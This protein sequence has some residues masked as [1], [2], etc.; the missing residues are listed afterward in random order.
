MRE[1]KTHVGVVAAASARHPATACKPTGSTSQSRAATANARATQ[2]A[3]NGRPRHKLT[4]A[5]AS[6]TAPAAEAASPATPAAPAS[7]RLLVL[8]VL[9]A[10]L[11]TAI[12][13][14]EREHSTPF[15]RRSQSQHRDAVPTRHVTGVELG[16]NQI[17]T[18]QNTTSRSQNWN[19]ATAVSFKFVPRAWPG[20]AATQSSDTATCTHTATQ[21]HSVRAKRG[22]D[23]DADTTGRSKQRHREEAH[24]FWPGAGRKSTAVSSFLTCIVSAAR[25][26]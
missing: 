1:R 25:G 18:Q 21:A 5:S 10:L 7:R 6:A 16:L 13:C 15:I 26:K 2:Q 22:A 3:S 8:L 9:L 20:T 11:R 24:D 19:H 12:L 17:T 4:S 23:A 14:S